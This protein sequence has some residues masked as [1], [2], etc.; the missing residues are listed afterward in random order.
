MVFGGPMDGSLTRESASAAAKSPVLPGWLWV[1]VGGAVGAVLVTIIALLVLGRKP[2]PPAPK[3]EVDARAIVPALPVSR[4]AGVRV[5]ARP[6][7]PPVPATVTFTIEVRPRK[8]SS[9][10]VFAD[11]THPGPRLQATVKR[12]EV[13]IVVRVKAK[14]YQTQSLS[15]VPLES[16]TVQ[17]VL[18]KE[19]RRRRR[20][21]RRLEWK[22][23]PR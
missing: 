17:V 23:L 5:D 11:E 6:V 15:L 14:G 22:P 20:R 13:A 7:A 9:R 21:R 3:L 2:D 1:V 10:I 16:R 19:Q 18:E 12:S 8:A 4:D